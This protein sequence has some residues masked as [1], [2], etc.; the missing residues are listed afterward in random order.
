MISAGPLDPLPVGGGVKS[1]F[2]SGVAATTPSATFGLTTW[3]GSPSSGSRQSSVTGML[4]V[5]PA[6][7]VKGF[8][9]YAA[10]RVGFP[11][12]EGTRTSTDTCA[13]AVAWVPL[14]TV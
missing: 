2:P 11:L 9:S 13:C 8:G 14:S 10:R 6:T 5:R 7:T 12:S 1:I 3:T 4:R